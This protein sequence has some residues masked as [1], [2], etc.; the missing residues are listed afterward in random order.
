MSSKLAVEPFVLSECSTRLAVSPPSVALDLLLFELALETVDAFEA[1][2][3][4]EL[5]EVTEL[6]ESVLLRLEAAEIVLSS[7]ELFNGSFMRFDC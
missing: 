4:F 2:L 5:T 1:A 6:S 3:D 7:S